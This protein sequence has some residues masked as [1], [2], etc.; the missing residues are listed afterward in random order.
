MAM[1]ELEQTGANIIGVILNGVGKKD[2][3]RNVENYDYFEKHGRKM[4]NR[5]NRTGTR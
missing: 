1:R 4:P 3:K 5:K 2:Y